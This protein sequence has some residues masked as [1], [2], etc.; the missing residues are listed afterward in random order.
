M[1]NIPGKSKRVTTAQ[2]KASVKTTEHITKYN[3]YKPM[4]ANNT[5]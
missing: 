1:T 2:Q 3:S 5:N 4:L